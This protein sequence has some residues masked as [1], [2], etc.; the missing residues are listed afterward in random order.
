[1]FQWDHLQ[2]P[3]QLKQLLSLVVQENEHLHKRLAALTRRLD[4]IEGGG[5][6]RQLELEIQALQQQVDN[7]QRKVFGASSEKR[8]KGG[9]N[10]ER[11]EEEK[12]RQTGHGP[13]KQPRLPLQEVVH[14]L[15][16]GERDCPACGGTLREMAGQSE[17]SEE[18][19]VIERQFLIRRHLRRKYRCRCNGAV[20]TAPCPPRLNGHRYALE[21][22][23][24]VA[25]DKYLDHLPLDRQVERMRRQG[26]EV[27][28]QTLWD[29]IQAAAA[30]LEPTY[31]AL[32]AHVL[33]QPQ[34]GADETWWRDLKGKKTC[35]DWCI[36]CEEGIYHEIHPSRSK[37]AAGEILRGYAGKVITDGYAAYKAVAR[38]SPEV[39]LLH[40]WAHVRRKFVEARPFY[41]AECQEVL[42]RIGEL[43]AVEASVPEVEEAKESLAL[44]ARLRRENSAGVIRKIR[45]WALAQRASPESG[46]RKAIEY[47]LEHWSGLTRFLEDPM[48][49]L[50][51]NATERA[52]R[53]VVL[54][55]KNHLGSRS[56]RGMQVAGLYYSLLD[57]AKICGV[58]PRQYLLGALRLAIQEPGSVLLPH[59]MAQRA[60]STAGG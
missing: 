43:Y 18:I 19:A 45:D 42:D 10:G 60:D 52:L 38:G 4:E 51:N 40:C 1:M 44:R 15:P 17:E 13:R 16:E 26:L 53:A 29:Q 58:D 56:K 3:D 39:T 14:E 28:S 50:D 35:Y 55:R 59:Q 23:V 32:K 48:I 6:R 24:E 37:E 25:V 46:L 30:R 2:D 8:G 27:E 20:V 57:T 49:P 31:A 41:P 11:P 47:M 5:E 9:G 22:A 7:F 12:P 54:G 34:I 36:C 21:F 33:S